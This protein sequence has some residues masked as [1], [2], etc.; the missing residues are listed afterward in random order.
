MKQLPNILIVLLARFLLVS[1]QIP[2]TLLPVATDSTKN[3]I[4]PYLTY[5]WYDGNFSWNNSKGSNYFNS[6][7]WLVY[8][9]IDSVDRH[10]VIARNLSVDGFHNVSFSEKMVISDT[11]LAVEVQNP[12]LENFLGNP[13]AIWEQYENGRV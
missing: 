3:E 13:V 9:E 5:Y 8:V 2:I 12:I 10:R 1:A 11:T 6:P 4:E 7:L